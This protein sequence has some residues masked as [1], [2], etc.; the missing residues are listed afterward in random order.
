MH[1]WDL[2]PKEAVALQRELAQSVRTDVPLPVEHVRL[3]AGV[4]VS[5]GKFDPMLTAGLIVWDRLSGKIIERVSFRGPETFPYIPG[6][7]SFREIPVLLEAAKQLQTEPDVFVVDGH[8]IAHPRR[9]GIATHLGL[10][11]QRP[12]LGIAKSLLVGDDAGLK[13]RAGSTLPIIDRG[14]VV[15]M[16]LRTK[17]SVK[18]VY[19][20]P[21]HLCDLPSALAIVTACCGRYRIPEPTRLAHEWV[22][23]VRRSIL[24]EP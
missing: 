19:V 12:T 15:G 3:V 11:L 18:P 22:N 14:E 21:G 10:F 24:A 20:S 1:S 23:E 8:G 2:L 6:L 9:M 7:L 13:A 16:S 4:D 5:G 17:D